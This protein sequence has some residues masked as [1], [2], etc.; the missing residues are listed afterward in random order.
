M[1]NINYKFENVKNA[2]PA[3]KRHLM[4]F[5]IANERCDQ[6][7]EP[8]YK[9]LVRFIGADQQDE[10]RRDYQNTLPD[11]VIPLFDTI[12]L[13]TDGFGFSELYGTTNAG[14]PWSSEQ[15]F[16]EI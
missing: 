8:G 2:L 3:A 13:D 9:V 4:D 7:F 15:G 1:P 6:D 10:C 16:Y 5:L 11:N 14:V 12:D